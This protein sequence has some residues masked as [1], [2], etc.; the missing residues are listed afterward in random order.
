MHRKENSPCN[1]KISVLT[2]LSS[3]VQRRLLLHIVL[4]SAVQNPVQCCSVL[5]SADQCSTIGVSVYARTVIFS[6]VQV[7][8]V[9][10]SE[11]TVLFSVC[12]VYVSQVQGLF[13]NVSSF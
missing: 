10:Y 3:A 11:C 13:G 12:T 2:V 4:S 7:S 8:G 5:Y 6:G 9:L 1:M